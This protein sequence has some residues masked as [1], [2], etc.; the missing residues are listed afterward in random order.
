MK[1]LIFVLLLFPAL[2][3]AQWGQFFKTFS[4]LITFDAG[5]SID[6]SIKVGA[7]DWIGLGSSK[8]RLEF[9]DQLEDVINVKSAYLFTYEAA[10]ADVLT[11]LSG[12]SDD[13]EVQVYQNNSKVISF[14]AASGADSYINTSGK[15]GINDASPDSTLDVTGSGAFSGNLKVGGKITATGGVDPPYI[16]FNAETEASIRKRSKGLMPDQAVMLFW[17]EGGKLGL[18]HVEE[19]RFYYIPLYPADHIENQRKTLMDG[20]IIE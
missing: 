9:K 2:A 1:K 3:F 4:E 10:G 17:N 8:G 13:G 15:L 6:D 16:S 7:D 5:I 20:I 11:G 19:D 14:N 18:Y 12:A